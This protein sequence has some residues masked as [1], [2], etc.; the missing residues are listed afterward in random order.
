[1]VHAQ[2]VLAYEGDITRAFAEVGPL[3]DIAPDGRTLPSPDVAWRWDGTEW[4]PSAE[5]S[6]A[7]AGETLTAIPHDNTLWFAWAAFKPETRIFSRE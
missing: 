1:M 5:P 2:C 3:T 4:S 7:L 6:G